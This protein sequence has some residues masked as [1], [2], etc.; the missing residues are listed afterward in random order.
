M[1][2]KPEP[3][4]ELHVFP[5]GVRIPFTFDGGGWEPHPDGQGGYRPT[6]E[7]ERGTVGLPCPQCGKPL[8]RD[9]GPAIVRRSAFGCP[10]PCDAKLIGDELY[11]AIPE[12]PDPGAEQV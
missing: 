8:V 1:P 10:H 5:E 9:A 3:T 2:K 11:K 12:P 4:P 6:A 7:G